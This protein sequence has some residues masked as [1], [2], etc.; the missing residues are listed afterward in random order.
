[1]IA[2]SFVKRN[3]EEPRGLSRLSRLGRQSRLNII[4]GQ[5]CVA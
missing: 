5:F 3:C 2:D 4:V 1:M